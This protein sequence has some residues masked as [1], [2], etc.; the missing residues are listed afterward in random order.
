MES[1]TRFGNVWRGMYWNIYATDIMRVERS[2]KPGQ[3]IGGG[4]LGF[5][6]W[7][8]HRRNVIEEPGES[9]RENREPVNFR[10]LS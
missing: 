2:T 6:D 5:P 1:T 4:C 3:G 7:R 8:V 10:A 9:M